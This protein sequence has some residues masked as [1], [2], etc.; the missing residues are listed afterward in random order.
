[1]ADHIVPRI[2]VHVRSRMRVSD[3]ICEEC[4]VATADFSF[5]KAG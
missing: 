2:H 4:L 1:M 3:L 5:P